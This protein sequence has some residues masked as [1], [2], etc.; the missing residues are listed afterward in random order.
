MAETS[1]SVAVKHATD[2]G[3]E[4][5]D[6]KRARVDSEASVVCNVIALLGADRAERC[7]GAQDASPQD[8]R[9]AGL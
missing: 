2:N 4:E 3:A 9:T 8:G 5:S 6:A 1:S 7:E